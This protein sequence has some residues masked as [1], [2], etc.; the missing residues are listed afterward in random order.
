[1]LSFAKLDGLGVSDGDQK[2]VIFLSDV[3][4]FQDVSQ[5]EVVSVLWDHVGAAEHRLEEQEREGSESGE[6]L[7]FDEAQGSV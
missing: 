7:E 3:A 4:L 5:I 2:T 1:M 6:S